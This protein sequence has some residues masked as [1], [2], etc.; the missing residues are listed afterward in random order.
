MKLVR[1][2][3]WNFI[4]ALAKAKFIPISATFTEVTKTSESTFMGMQ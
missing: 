2:K 3:M 1:K 4:P